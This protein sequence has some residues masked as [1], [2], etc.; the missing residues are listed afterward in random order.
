MGC[1]LPENY[2]KLPAIRKI[3]RIKMGITF[4]KRMAY[5]RNKNSENIKSKRVKYAEKFVYYY[6]QKKNFIFINECVVQSFNDEAI[7]MGP[8]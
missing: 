1:N 8:K 5:Q 7:W 6:E 2:I 4:K 3:I